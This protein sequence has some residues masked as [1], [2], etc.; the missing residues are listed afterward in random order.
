MLFTDF[1]NFTKISEQLT[2]EQFVHE[3]DTYFKSFDFIIK[4]YNIEKIKTI[5]DAYMCAIGLADGQTS[6]LALVK[7]GLEMQEYIN[8][9]KAEKMQ[10][11]EPFF[12]LKVGIHTGPVVAGVVGINKFAYDIWGDTVNIAARLQDNCEPGKVNIS[13][14]VYWAVKYKYDC[15][16]RGKIQAKNKGAIDMYYIG[17][18]KKS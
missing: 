6:P 9:V 13:E 14:A 1:R 8:D 3:L 12:E 10:R 17:A 5:G 18:E 7:A 11:N 2:P 16:P 15:I 4:P